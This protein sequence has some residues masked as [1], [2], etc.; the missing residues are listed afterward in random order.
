MPAFTRSLLVCLAVIAASVLP[1][2]PAVAQPVY[3]V[4]DLGQAPP[5]PDREPAPYTC[6]ADPCP[7]LMLMNG[8]GQLVISRR[9][10]N[11]ADVYYWEPGLN[12]PVRVDPHSDD[13]AYAAAISSNGIVVGTNSG[14]FAV[15]FVWSRSAGYRALCCADTYFPLGVNA[16]GVV[17][18]FRFF[19][20]FRA[21]IWNNLATATYIDDLEIS[22]GGPWERFDWAR[23]IS[24][25]GTISGVGQLRTS[26]GVVQ[27][28]YFALI[29]TPAGSGALDRRD[30]TASATEWSAD[31]PPSQAIDGNIGTRFSTGR[32]QHD[33]Q[34]FSVTWPGDRTIGRIRMEVG[35]SSGD[36][37]RTCGIWVTDTSGNVTFVDC[38]ADASGIVDVSFTPLPVNK[39]EVWQWGAASSWW[40][41]AELNVFKP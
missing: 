20:G 16:S 25:D 9:L 37:P 19:G 18:G 5:L 6:P 35:P 40:S 36:Y 14:G 34:G 24:D 11:S 1:V 23:T 29:P 12:A 7:D 33:S 22:G 28:H 3:A 30:W 15:P 38:A 13:T 10:R 2:S 8:K 32:A 27:P 17:V 4:V 21:V 41:I 39:I 26:S 31:D